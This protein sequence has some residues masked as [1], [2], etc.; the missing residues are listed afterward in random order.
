MEIR[1]LRGRAEGAEGWIQDYKREVS[2][3]ESAATG[4]E[5]RLGLLEKEGECRT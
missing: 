5:E 3:W 4:Y 1:L 2:K